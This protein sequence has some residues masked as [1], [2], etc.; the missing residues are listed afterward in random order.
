MTSTIL[1]RRKVARDGGGAES[2]VP[3]AGL[4]PHVRDDMDQG[5]AQVVFAPEFTMTDLS[6]G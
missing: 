1:P 2:H 5:Y 6:D 3:R 4:L